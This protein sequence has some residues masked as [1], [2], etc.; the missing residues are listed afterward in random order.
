MEKRRSR[1]EKMLQKKKR[2]KGGKGCRTGIFC[3]ESDD[4]PQ[5]SFNIESSAPIRWEWEREGEN[6]RKH[7]YRELRVW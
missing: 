3:N 6:N 1:K 7:V 4:S 5:R 2:T